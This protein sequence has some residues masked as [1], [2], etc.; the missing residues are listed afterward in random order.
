MVQGVSSH[1]WRRMMVFLCFVFSAST[2]MAWGLSTHI[3]R[4]EQRQVTFSGLRRPCGVSYWPSAS[5]TIR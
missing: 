4:G 5:P 1:D 3:D 2:R